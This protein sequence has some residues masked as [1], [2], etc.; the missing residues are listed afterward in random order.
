MREH[1]IAL[2]VLGR[3]DAGKTTFVKAVH[4]AATARPGP[5]AAEE[6]PTLG[7]IQYDVTLPDGQLL[8]FLDTPGFDGYQPGGEPAKETE[9]ILQMLEDHLAANESRPVSHVLVFLNANDMLH[10]I[11]TRWDQVE[12]DDGPPTTAE[13]A[14]SREESLYETGKTNGSLLEYL[15]VGRQNRGGDI[16]RFRSGLPNEAY[17]SPQDIVHKLFTQPG[18]DTTLEER[19]A[20]MTKERDDL[21]AKYALLL[22][23][24]K[25]STPAPAT[26]GPKEALPLQE[27]QT[28][29]PAPATP[30]PKEAIRA[31]RTR[32]QRLLDTIDKFS[33]QVLEMVAELDREALDIAEE[34]TACRAEAEAASAAI[35]MAEGKLEEAKEDVKAAEEECTQLKQGQDSLAE[36]ERS[37]SAQLNGLEPS[38]GQRSV[39]VLPSAK[40]RIISSLK[41]TQALHKEREDW[42]SVA[43]DYYQKGCQEVQQAGA[44]V[45]KWKRI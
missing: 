16:R 12:D 41:Q 22:Q 3:F 32:R 14:R 37:L 7:V 31:P 18:S 40:Q 45:E 11:T 39:R 15:L 4:N 19:L 29:S 33:A 20:A 35:K 43:D 36:L 25:A 5:R 27:K 17:S 1:T 8:T 24:K 42:V 6:A 26:P 21:A 38:V 23:E 10:G 9:E 13:E 2:S 44:E 30:A 34:C 28:W